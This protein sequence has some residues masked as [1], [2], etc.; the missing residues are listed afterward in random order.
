VAE[1]PLAPLLPI[2]EELNNLPL[3]EA[4]EVSS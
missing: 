2:Y 1:I 3:I 4:A